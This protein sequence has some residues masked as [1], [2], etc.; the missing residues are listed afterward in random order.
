MLL[1]K[2]QLENR[3]L[4]QLRRNTFMSNIFNGEPSIVLD[5]RPFYS[6]IIPCYNSRKTIGKLLES[7]I[8]QNMNDDIE[9]I[10]SDDHSTESYQ[11]IVDGFKQILS[12][13]QIQTDYNFAPGNTRERGVSIAKGEWIAFADHDDEF[14]S[15]TLLPI[16][17]AIL[18]KG[19]K[20]YA[21]ANFLEVEPDS[22]KVLKEMRATRNWNHAKFY[23]LDNLWKAYNIHFKKD[24]LTH[25]DIYVSSCI[26]CAIQKANGGNPLYI[27][28]FCYVWNNRP[29]TIS[30]EKYG[31][32]TF[33]EVFYEDYITS[34]GRVYLD[35][36]INRTA[37][38]Q[39]A[40]GSVIEVLLYCYFYTESFKFHRPNDYLTKND[41]ASRQYLVAIKNAFGFN[42]DYIVNY[43]SQN[44]A[45]MY[46]AVRDSAA[47]GA[48]YCVE[49]RTFAQWLDWLHADIKPRITMS[50]AIMSKLNTPVF[51]KS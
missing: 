4:I 51:T 25:E 10:L 9:V 15:D 39:Y 17:N 5:H 48:G 33:L 38:L 30:R 21:I 12:I 19:E 41:D 34:T 6:I 22:G 26:N 1:S 32:H 13:K 14:L 31:D 20:Y 23:N 36:Y 18:D 27:D 24:L 47:D 50:D 16:K 49:S 2:K 11:D 37:S 45:I 46:S 3:K 40:E 44:D 42:N 29:T 8:K 35:N 43:V 28:I 7:I